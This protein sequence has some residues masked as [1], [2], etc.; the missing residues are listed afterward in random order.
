MNKDKYMRGQYKGQLKLVAVRRL[1]RQHNQA[2]KINI[3]KLTYEQTL[4]KLKKNGFDINHEKETIQMIPTKLQPAKGRKKK[5]VIN[6]P[7]KDVKVVNTNNNP[8]T[9]AGIDSAFKTAQKITPILKKV[10][11]PKN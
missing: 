7:A 6:I 9:D 2:S 3:Q 5:V 1:V 4:A 8:F 11:M 10:K